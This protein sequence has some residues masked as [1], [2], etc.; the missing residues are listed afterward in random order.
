M[1]NRLPFKCG[2]REGSKHLR[3]LTLIR[4]SGFH[5][6]SLRLNP[7]NL[8]KM[9]EN[10]HNYL[11][12]LRRNRHFTKAKLQ[13]K[14]DSI[15]LHI[16]NM[17]CCTFDDGS[18]EKKTLPLDKCDQVLWK[19][20]IF[21]F[22]ISD[23]YWE[24]VEVFH[25]ELRKCP[26]LTKDQISFLQQKMFR[27]GTLRIL[28]SLKNV[29]LTFGQN[30]CITDPLYIN[31]KTIDA[32]FMYNFWYYVFTECFFSWNDIYENVSGIRLNP[33]EWYYIRQI[34][35]ERDLGNYHFT[36]YPD[37]S[38]TD[39][40]FKIGS[41]FHPAGLIVTQELPQN[42]LEV[43]PVN[44]EINFK[45]IHWSKQV[46]QYRYPLFVSR[47]NTLCFMDIANNTCTVCKNLK[48]KRN[49]L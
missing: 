1:T 49:N 43:Y 29:L 40:C 47:K 7:S 24:M 9:D 8:I 35:S 33:V 18:Y 10:R 20:K 3:P 17:F 48:R 42:Q 26:G 44:S 32:P 31:W 14:I 4:H 36:F 34:T 27:V 41:D 37:P 30:K 16:V 15:F 46:L 39:R 19:R 6:R 28:N 21:R 12:S 45:T 22:F 11:R 25:E 23:T 13:R 2:V 38:I 5:L